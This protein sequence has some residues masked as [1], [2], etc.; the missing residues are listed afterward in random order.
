M[1]PMASASD[2]GIMP[3]STAT[4]TEGTWPARVSIIDDHEISRAAFVA[5]LRAEGIDVTAIPAVSDQVIMATRAHRPDV[6]IID[7]TPAADTGFAIADALLTLP[8]PPILILTSSTGR[9]HFGVQLNGH[10]F[11]AKADIC[12]AGIT[13]LA[14]APKTHR[15]ESPNRRVPRRGTQPRR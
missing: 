15:P 13:R 7:V 10:R 9:T 14:T 11:I 4:P 1:R 12:T 8:A 5:L 2:P 3:A 6:A